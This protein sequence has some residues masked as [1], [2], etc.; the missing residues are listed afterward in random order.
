MWR[1]RIFNRV[2]EVDAATGSSPTLAGIWDIYGFYGDGGSATLANLWDPTG[3]A[4]D[5][6]GNQYIADWANC[7]IREVSA[8][9]LLM[10]SSSSVKPALLLN[11]GNAPLHISA[12]AFSV[13]FATDAA[14]TT[15]SLTSPLAVGD[16]CAIGV[17]WTGSGIFAGT[18]TITDDALNQS[19]ATQQMQLFVA[20][21]SPFFSPAQGVYIQPQSV[22][23]S[24]ATPGAAI[25]YTT[26]GS[27]PTTAST[28]YTG[29]IAVNSTTTIQAVAAANG[30][31]LSPV[32]SA[33]YAMYTAPVTLNP[34]P[35]VFASAQ[36]VT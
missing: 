20:T 28:P 7:R 15:C 36:T 27:T 10:I 13:G 4:L 34:G 18:L 6:A 11:I 26:D 9:G 17:V 3:I 12:I 32:N 30:F 31:P 16:S 29:P 8:S 25:Y 19:G 35:G 24:D 14:T 23:V 1:T 21:A 22:T 5:A 33:T 2:F